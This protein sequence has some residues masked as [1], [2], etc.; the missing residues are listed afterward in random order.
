MTTMKN[1]DVAAAAEPDTD[2]GAVRVTVRLIILVVAST[3]P[4]FPL[5]SAKHEL[6]D[7]CG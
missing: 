1:A 5:M 7:V 3:R 4:N 2:R 6:K